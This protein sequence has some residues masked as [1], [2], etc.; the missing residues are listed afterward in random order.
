MTVI[1]SP[2]P[3]D[4]AHAA[5]RSPGAD[6]AP[7]DMTL[8]VFLGGWHASADAYQPGLPPGWTCPE[9]PGFGE[10]GGFFAA[11]VD[12]ALRL[13]RAA[14]GAAHIAG[15]SL[16]GAIAIAVAARE[17]GRVARVTGFA[18][19]GVPWS[20][21]A[22]RAAARDMIGNGLGRRR[23]PRAGSRSVPAALEDPRAAL[24]LARTLERL[25]LRHELERVRAAGTELLVVGARGD[26]VAEPEACRRIAELGG[27]RYVEDA[28]GRDHLW[29]MTDPCRL[30]AF[31]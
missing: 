16:G 15:H 25:D 5:A 8:R 23:A 3:H 10:T 17:P 6:G 4:P 14:G 27:G 30:A 20:S 12:W 22:L 24:R 9:Q 28:A 19:A 11:Y 31:L 1:M 21:G 26:R 13:V 2:S 7:A 18:P 29:V